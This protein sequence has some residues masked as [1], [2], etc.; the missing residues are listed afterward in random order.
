MIRDNIRLHR[1][2]IRELSLACGRA[3]DAVRM[4]VV[5]KTVPPEKVNIALA[6]GVDLIGENRVQEL[7]EKKLQIN[8]ENSQIHFIGHLQTNKIRDI[9]N[10]VSCVQSLDSIRLAE[11]LSAAA[12]KAGQVMPCLLEVNIGMEPSK[13]GFAPEEVL[14]AAEKISSLPGISLHGLMT[15]Q[16]SEASRSG[17]DRYFQQM[18]EL[19]LALRE[20]NSDPHRIDTLSM[21]M[22]GDY[23][24]AVRC[25]AT[26]VRIGQGIF[27]AR[28]YA[29][30]GAPKN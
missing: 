4:M 29:A 18:Q 24:T 26:M 5:T 27:G 14:S 11:A 10:K 12:E 1:D 9:I 20:Q 6:E 28:Q 7:C 17:D 3:E 30:P 22:S 8:V 19:F 16:P 13:S 23:Q 25:G 2:R 15:V 21:G